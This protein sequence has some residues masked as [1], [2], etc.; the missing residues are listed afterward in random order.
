MYVRGSQWPGCRRFHDNASGY[1]G[2]HPCLCL[3]RLAWKLAGGLA[4]ASW[5]DLM[6]VHFPCEAWHLAELALLFLTQAGLEM[7]SR[8]ML[9]LLLLSLYLG[10]LQRRAGG[11]VWISV[12]HWDFSLAQ[13]VAYGGLQPEPSHWHHSHARSRNVARRGCGQR[14]LHRV[15]L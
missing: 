4:T 5:H 13:Q 11:L 3:L 9:A 7:E 14:G 6:Q 12:Q 10:L 15:P 1:C 8:G 2:R